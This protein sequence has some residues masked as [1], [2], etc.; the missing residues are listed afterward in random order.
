M[1]LQHNNISDLI[2]STARDKLNRFANFDDVANC[3]FKP[4][5]C[6]KKER[7][8]GNDDDAV[9]GEANVQACVRTMEVKERSKQTVR[10]ILIRNN[11]FNFLNE[12]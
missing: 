1:F 12:K 2:D 4:K 11:L 7:K 10:Y 9:Q 8:D 5:I 6:S 3:V